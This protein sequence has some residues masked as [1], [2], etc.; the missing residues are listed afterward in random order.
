MS[1]PTMGQIIPYLAET[2]TVYALEAVRA[3]DAGKGFAVVAVE[4]Q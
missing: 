3:C 1:I 2:N 4:V